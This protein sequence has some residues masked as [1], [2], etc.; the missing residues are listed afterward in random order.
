MKRIYPY[1][2]QDIFYLSRLLQALLCSLNESPLQVPLHALSYH[3]QIPEPIFQRLKN[4]HQQPEDAPNI[5]PEDYHILFSNILFR[6]P[7][8]RMF[9]LRDQQIFIKM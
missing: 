1:Q 6:Y 4:L 3:T 5:R 2:I 8:V 7:T 9:Q